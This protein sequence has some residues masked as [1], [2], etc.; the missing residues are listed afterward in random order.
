VRQL[1]KS[2]APLLPILAIGSAARADAEADIQRAL[3]ERQQRADEL[4]LR[5]QQ[6][7]PPS[8]GNLRQQ[9][10]LDRLHLQNL[11]RLQNLNAQQLRQFDASRQA[12]PPDPGAGRL[13]LQQQQFERDR[14]IELQQLRWEEQ[15]LLDSQQRESQQRPL[16]QN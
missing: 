6:S 5:I 11:Q 16:Q 14:Q 9:Q 3:I 2:L 1:L 13:Q 7:R 10:E 12:S 4:T 15:R 8:P